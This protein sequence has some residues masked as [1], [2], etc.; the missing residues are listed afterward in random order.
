MSGPPGR[1]FAWSRASLHKSLPVIVG[2]VVGGCAGALFDALGA[3]AAW[4]TG[5]IIVVAAARYGR[6]PIAASPTIRDGC[7]I[8]LGFTIGS[9]VDPDT[10]EKGV[11]WAPSIALV[12]A[13]SLATILTV[14]AFLHF[15]TGWDRTTSFFSSIP[16][17]LVAAVSIAATTKADLQKI[18]ICHLTRLAL[19][20][21]AFPFAMASLGGLPGGEGAGPQA[22]QGAFGGAEVGSLVAAGVVGVILLR[23]KIPA[24]PLLGS[25]AVS[26]VAHA[27]G[28]ANAATPSFL[29]IAAY[30]GVGVYT[31]SR[32]GAGGAI[33]SGGAFIGGLASL[34][35]GL[36]IAAVL[37]LVASQF[38]NV[39]LAQLL[40]AYAPGGIEVMIVLALTS[41]YDPAFIGLHQI[42]RY[43]FV[44]TLMLFISR[45][46]NAA[47]RQ[48]S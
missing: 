35:C 26:L 37:A 29:L 6:L 44:T 1:G 43:L 31:G 47:G 36:S 11:A 18:T 41:G 3:P 14:G 12:L 5:P 15:A 2:L 28:L 39:P 4:L 34:A 17:S 8:V 46:H 32:I 25:L 13:G 20:S 42:A 7:F 40:F 48:S 24:G 16:G 21:T 30:V 45:L 23:A 19:I 22:V 33:F 10:V 9:Y 38:T 27:T